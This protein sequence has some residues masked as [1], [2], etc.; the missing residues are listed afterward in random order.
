MNAQEIV[1]ILLDGQTEKLAEASVHLPPR[2][3][4]YVATFTG[5]EPGQQIWKSTGLKNRRAA[6]ALARKWEQ[7]ARHER[8][9]CA[10]PPRK[11]SLRVRPRTSTQAPAVGLT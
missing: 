3:S 10:K 2:S 11:P 9:A 4:N 6:L 1:E 7:Q 8:R 5:P